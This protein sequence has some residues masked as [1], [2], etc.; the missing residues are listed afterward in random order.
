MAAGSALVAASAVEDA[1]AAGDPA[2]LAHTYPAA[3]AAFPVGADLRTFAAAPRALAS[4]RLS[5]LYPR[6]AADLLRR[7]YAHDG[8]PRDHLARL[9]RAAVRESGV[10]PLAL[11]R[12][13]LTLGRAL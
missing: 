3:L 9:A 11:A 5:G 8:A 2:Q 4:E 1:L 13:A 6:L 10:G 7:A 12:D